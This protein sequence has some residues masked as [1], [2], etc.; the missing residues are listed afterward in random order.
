MTE[1]N[2]EPVTDEL[3]AEREAEEADIVDIYEDAPQI[4][5]AP[6]TQSDDQGRQDD[7]Q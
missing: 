4:D 5:D 7:D 2:P 1:Q 6:W 3:E